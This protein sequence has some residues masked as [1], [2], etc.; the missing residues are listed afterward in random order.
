MHHVQLPGGDTFWR[1]MKLWNQLEIIMVSN[2]KS[3]FIN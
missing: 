3:D 1:K 2:Q